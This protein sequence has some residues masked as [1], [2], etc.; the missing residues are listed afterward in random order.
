MKPPHCDRAGAA[1]AGAWGWGAVWWE[2][3]GVPSFVYDALPGR[4]VFGAGAARTALAAEVERLGMSRLLLIASERDAGRG[5]T[6]PFAGRVAAVFT[7][8]REHVPV[9]TAEAAREAA[10]GADGVLCVGG[11]SAVGAAKAVAL[12]TRLPILAVPTTYAGSEVTPVWG[13]SDGGVKTT[14]TDPAVLPRT[15]VYDPELTATLPPELATASALNALAHCVEAFWAPRRNPVSSAV[16]EEGVRALAAGLRDG[17]PAQLLLGAY[18]AGSAFAV[19][20]SGLHHKLAHVLGGLGMPH[21]RTHAT[22]LPHVLAFNAPGSPEATARVARALG[23]DDVGRDDAVA[24]LH[25]VTAAAG[26]PRGL[27][28]LGLAEDRLDEVVERTLP[29]VPADNPVPVDAAALRRL[30][31]AAWAG[32]AE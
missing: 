12:T 16:A 2:G 3:G 24:G 32:Q 17:D 26:I 30:V 23:R 6:A 14:G 11:G 19:A 31:R 5:L 4:I 13:L 27:A 18:L 21:A 8:V 29:A 9:A 25:A 22:L 28:E 15:V 10:A 1:G 7:A 20:G